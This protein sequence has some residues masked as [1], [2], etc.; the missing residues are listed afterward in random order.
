[1][2]V[3]ARREGML[4]DNRPGLVGSVRRMTASPVLPLKSWPH[5]TRKSRSQSRSCVHLQLVERASSWT[6]GL[7][8]QGS[9]CF[10]TANATVSLGSML[11]S[12]PGPLTLVTV[13]V[14]PLAVTLSGQRLQVCLWRCCLAALALSGGSRIRQRLRMLSFLTRGVLP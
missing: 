11:S 5:P 7:G 3:A 8:L 2:A 14:M 6:A 12:Y 1:M 10:M 4:M 13:Q 9:V